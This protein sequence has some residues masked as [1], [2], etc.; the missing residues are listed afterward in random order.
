MNTVVVIAR[1][2]VLFTLLLMPFFVSAD[3]ETK[4]TVHIEYD[5]A[6]KEMFHRIFKRSCI[7]LMGSGCDGDDDRCCPSDDPGVKNRCVR[8]LVLHGGHLAPGPHTCMAKV[9]KD[10]IVGS[11]DIR[12]RSSGI[13]R[14]YRNQ[15]KVVEVKDESAKGTFRRPTGPA[16]P[17]PS[18]CSVKLYQNANYDGHEDRYNS[19]IGMVRHNDDASSVKPSPGCCVTV[20]EHRDY[21]GKS[22]R[23]CADSP[24]LGRFW[25]DRVSSLK[26]DSRT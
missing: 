8:K 3:P 16:S 21:L 26:V 20:Y 2:S 24:F 25:N 15:T 5:D 12:K 9:K 1:S 22:L 13:P 6:V 18:V 19:N 23:I 10:V 7:P 17:P 11:V 4:I 14:S